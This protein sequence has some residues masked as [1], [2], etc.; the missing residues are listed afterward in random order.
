L[1]KLTRFLLFLC[2]AAF[3]LTLPSSA[4]VPSVNPGQEGS[5][6]PVV[7]FDFNWGIAQPSHYAIAVESTGSAAYR[8]DEEK[9]SQEAQADAYMIKFLVSEP[10]RD[11][12]FELVKE[13]N[14]FNGDFEYTKTRV[15]Q[16]G[17]KT[18][19][20]L[21]GHLPNDFEHP[22]RGRKNQA[23]YNW[24]QNP[25]IQQLTQIFQSMSATFELGRTLDF[26]RRFDKLALDSE[27]KRAEEMQNTGDLQQVQVIAPV[28]KNIA[29][30]STVMHI[31]R[32]RAKRILAKAEN[33]Q[34]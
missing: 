19:T 29:N 26:K 27:L 16:T 30:D 3:L 11:K 20:F 34:Q 1:P 10:T 2:C 4:Q 22:V 5:P 8:S 23:T 14:F 13:S 25:A 15:A 6:V 12:I 31:A 7:I 32:Q 33:A 9:P 18:L 24:S 17:V 28:L 21:V